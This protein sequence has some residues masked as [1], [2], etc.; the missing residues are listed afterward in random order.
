MI[1]CGVTAIGGHYLLEQL[2]LRY[3]SR[4]IPLT[5]LILW[6][7]AWGF[8]NYDYQQRYNKESDI[9]KYFSEDRI[10]KIREEYKEW[11]LLYPKIGMMK[12]NLE[13]SYYR[14]LIREKK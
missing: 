4:A 11:Q 3:E 8:I 13:Y 1:I 7:V 6:C 9:R 2:L 10:K 5:F 14:L 12:K